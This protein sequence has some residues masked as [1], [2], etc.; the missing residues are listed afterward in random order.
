[1]GGRGGSLEG[2]GQ[3]SETVK[4]NLGFCF[5]FKVNGEVLGLTPPRGAE[6][7]SAIYK[8]QYLEA[9][10]TKP[11]SAAGQ[12]AQ[13]FLGPAAL[14]PQ[15]GDSRLPVTPVPEDQTSFWA[16]ADLWHVYSCTHTLIKKLFYRGKKS[17]FIKLLLYFSFRF[18]YF[19]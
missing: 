6:W 3:H 4:N 17:D 10:H 5:R 11:G 8:N 12:M 18:I 1:M 2:P 13:Q 16:P 15:V 14:S 9:G 19:I 7:S